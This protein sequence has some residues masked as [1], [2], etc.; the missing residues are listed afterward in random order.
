MRQRKNSDLTRRQE[1]RDTEELLGENITN[2]FGTRDLEV[3]E[4]NLKTMRYEDMIELARKVGI[5]VHQPS[6]RIVATLKKEFIER[7][8]T[9]KKEYSLDET[10]RTKNFDDLSE[11]DRDE[12]RD[13]MYVRGRDE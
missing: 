3:F 1:V 7:Y 11:E 8:G 10:K 2:V 5:N 9:S 12:I 6:Q 13:L 4:E